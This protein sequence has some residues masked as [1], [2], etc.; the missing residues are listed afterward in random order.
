MKKTDN[1]KKIGKT[2]RYI[3]IIILAVFIFLN[4][5]PYLLPVSDGEAC[6]TNLPFGESEIKEV[7]N[8]AIHYRLWIPNE[9]IKGKILMIHGLGGSTFSWLQSVEPLLEEGYVVV[10]AD[11]P[12]FGYSDRTPGQDH[13]QKA[14]SKLIWELTKII[15]SEINE[16]DNDPKKQVKFSDL[17]WTLAGHS[18]GSGTIAAMAMEKPENVSSLI[19][20][21]GAVFDH[22]P[23]RRNIFFKYPPVQRWLK[24]ILHNYAIQP[25]RI[26]SFL[27]SAYGREPADYEVDGY[28]NPL[29]QSGTSNTM[30]D[31][32]KTAKNEP[33]ENLSGTDIPVLGVW[34]ENDTWVPK[35]EGQKLKEILPDMQLEIIEDAAH[36]PMETHPEE[37]NSIILKFLSEVS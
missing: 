24:V 9:D 3:I 2:V 16:N 30:I 17:K 6:M 22:N 36:C 33:V 34:G 27:E 5:L 37:F 7:D 35:S 21:A 1:P 28:L 32:I 11:L 8:V 23:G 19:F 4:I 13:S 15:D 12:G 20:V 25:E 18:M 31:L 10:A 26:K 14:R 29:Q